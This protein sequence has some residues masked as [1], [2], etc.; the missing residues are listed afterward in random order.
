MPSSSP[1]DRRQEPVRANQPGAVVVGVQR[2][3]DLVQ[4][5][6]RRLHRGVRPVA[7]EEVSTAADTGRAQPVAPPGGRREHRNPAIAFRCDT[8]SVEHERR[9]RPRPDGSR[10]SRL[11]PW[12]TGGSMMVTLLFTDL[13]ASTELLARL[14]DDAAEGVRRA[15]CSLLRQAIA[16]TGGAEVK[17]LG[18]GLMVVF[19][20]AVEALRRAV[21][22]QRRID[23]HNATAAGPELAVRIG[24]QAGEPLRDG[25]DFHGEAVVTA[26]RLCHEAEGA[27]ILTSELVAALVGS[28]G[29]FRFR[30]AGRLRLKGLPE[31]VATVTVDWRPAEAGAP[32]A[33]SV[34]ST[35]ATAST[36]T[37][38]TAT[39]STATATT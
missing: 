28:R 34:A 15:H 2:D 18:D 16:E 12:A 23:Y 3:D 5:G 30:P 22:M 26:S 10:R 35:A 38:S 4:P 31:P 36:A 6:R 17:S 14:G 32:A 39:A 11:L 27:Q 7:L 19:G 1:L 9:F 29:G 13:V 37:A 20:S 25:D 33:T 8:P 24:V 21:G